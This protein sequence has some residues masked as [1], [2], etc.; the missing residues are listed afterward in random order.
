MGVTYGITS[1][2]NTIFTTRI[3]GF[4]RNF[5]SRKGS[6]ADRVVIDRE[7]GVDILHE[8]T[9]REMRVRMRRTVFLYNN[10]RIAKEPDVVGHLEVGRNKSTR[11]CALF[12][13]S[14]V[15]AVLQKHQT[16]LAP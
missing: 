16:N 7:G 13:L 4:H 12:G 10:S 1:L 9:K 5:P 8:A 15:E 3:P 14:E 6:K 11:A 2:K